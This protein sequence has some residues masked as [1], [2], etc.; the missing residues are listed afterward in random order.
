MYQRDVEV[1]LSS[2]DKKGVF[3]GTIFVHKQDYAETLLEEGLAVCFGR[4]SSVHYQNLE[5]NA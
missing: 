3:H 5:E 4:S 2:I 1:S